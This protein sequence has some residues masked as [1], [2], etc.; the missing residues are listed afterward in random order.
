[1]INKINTIAMISKFVKQAILFLSLLIGLEG[2]SANDKILNY[3]QGSDINNVGYLTIADQQFTGIF[4]SPVTKEEKNPYITATLRYEESILPLFGI[5]PNSMTTDDFSLT[6]T[7]DISLTNSIGNIITITNQT[8]NITYNSQG[9]DT[10]KDIDARRYYGYYEGDL[11]VTNVVYKSFD[12]TTATHSVSDI[13]EDVYLELSSE[14]ERYYEL[15]V[16]SPWN[17]YPVGS[18][19]SLNT[20]NELKISWDYILGAESF[21]V[22]WVFVDITGNAS[23][24]QIANMP[25]SWKNATRINTTNNYYNISMAYPS[26][27]IIY[28]VRPV[29]VDLDNG[30]HNIKVYGD[31]SDPGTT[32][33]TDYAYAQGNGFVHE[34]LDIGKNWTYNVAY[35]E[36]GKRKE[37]ISYFDGSA[38]S[39]QEVTILNSDKNAIVGETLYDFEG[40]PA[41]S[42]LP[43]P[44]TSSGIGFYENGS[45]PF[46][47]GYSKAN[48]DRDNNFVG[49]NGPDLMSTTLALTSNYYSPLTPSTSLFKDF[50]PDADSLPFSRTIYKRDGTDRITEQ[51]GVGSILNHGTA[52][53]TK[54]Y[55]GSP[56][57]MEIERLFGNEVGPAAFYQKN[58]VKDP[59]GQVSIQYLDKEGRTIATALAGTASSPLLD[60]DYQPEPVDIL[61]NLLS[62]NVYSAN[63]SESMHVLTVSTPGSVTLNYTLTGKDFVEACLDDFLDPGMST[64]NCSYKLTISVLDEDGVDLFTTSYTSPDL[65]FTVSCVVPSLDVGTYTITKTLEIDEV[66]RQEYI[67]DFK[68]AILDNKEIGT[69]QCVPYDPP[70]DVSCNMSC[71]ELC[72]AMLMETYYD[73]ELEQNVT[74]YYDENGNSA[75]PTSGIP[76]EYSDYTTFLANCQDACNEADEMSFSICELKLEAMKRQISPGGQYFD[77]FPTKYQDTSP[78]DGIADLD[79]NGNPIISSSYDQYDWLENN[80][81]STAPTAIFGTNP[82]TSTA[83]TWAE[84]EANWTA[85]PWAT[86]V[87]NTDWL[88]DLVKYHPEYCA[89]N[90]NCIE[91]ISI[92]E[93]TSSGPGTEIDRSHVIDYDFYMMSGGSNYLDR[94]KQETIL[95]PTLTEDYMD[96][97][98]PLGIA[99]DITN[100]GAANDNQQ[101]I[102]EVD[103]T[104]DNPSGSS[105]LKDPL[106]SCSSLNFTDPQGNSHVAETWITER[107]QKFIAVNTAGD[108][109]HSIWYVLNDVGGVTGSATKPT[110]MTQDA[111]DFYNNLL[112]NSNLS[113]AVDGIV[114][115]NGTTPTNTIPGKMNRYQFFRGVYKFYRDFILYQLFKEYDEACDDYTGGGDPYTYWDVDVVKDSD[116][117]TSWI[118]QLDLTSYNGTRDVNDTYVAGDE[119]DYF[120]LVW[121]RV[122]PYDILEVGSIANMITNISTLAE[123]TCEDDCD[124]NAN[125]WMIEYDYC[126][127]EWVSN[128]GLTTQ[129]SLNIIAELKADLIEICQL[130]C[131][132]ATPIGSSDGDGT[133][134]FNDV[135]FAAPTLGNSGNYGSLG[136]PA[137]PSSI[138]ATFDD[139]LAYYDS[140]FGATCTKSVEYPNPVQNIPAS[141]AQCNCDQLVAY[142]ASLTPTITP[143]FSSGNYTTIASELSTLTGD[144]YIAADVE[145]W[146]DY[147]NGVVG[148]II[149][150]PPVIECIDCKCENLA[151]FIT[152]RFGFDPYTLSGQDLTDVKD[153]I[154]DEFN[155][156]YTTTDITNMMAECEDVLV[157][158][159]PNEIENPYFVGL[160]DIFRCNSTMQI[161]DP[162]DDCANELNNDLLIAY[163]N[164]WDQQLAAAVNQF[165]NAYTDTCMAGIQT[166]ETFTAEYQLNE[167]MYTL[168]YYDQAGNLIKTVPP[169][170]VKPHVTGSG[171]P[172]VPHAF[173]TDVKN[174]RSDPYDAT[175][176]PS[177]TVHQNVDHTLVT[178]YKY[179]SYNNLIWQS[180]PDGGETQ[181]WYD[182]LGRLVLS[183]NAKQLANGTAQITNIYSYTLYDDLGRIKE[184]GELA[185]TTDF[186]EETDLTNYNVFET[187]VGTCTRTQVTSTYYDTYLNTTVDGYFYNGQQELRTRVSSI[188]REETHDGDKDTYDYATHFSYDIHGNVNEIIQDNRTNMLTLTHNPAK[189]TRITYEY[190]LISGNV[191]KVS[192]QPGK[193]EQYFHRYFYDA[194]NRITHAETSRDNFIWDTDAKYLY[195]EHGPL[196]RTEIGTKQVAGSD[197]AY[198]LQGWIKGVNSNTLTASLDIGRD[199]ELSGGLN[200]RFATD[201][202]GYGLGY[203]ADDYQAIDATF[204]ATT[205]GSDFAIASPSLYNGN[206]RHMVTALLDEGEDPQTVHGTAYRYDQANRIKSSNV[207]TGVT[208]NSFVGATDNNYYKTEHH[209]DLNGN[210]TQLNRHNHAGVWMDQLEY[211]YNNDGNGRNEHDGH[212]SSY[213]Y[214]N[215]TTP[216]AINKNQ[217]TKVLDS[218]GVVSTTDFGIAGITPQDFVYDEIGQLI[219]DDDEYIDEIV[220]DVYNKIK[221]I[222]YSLNTRPDIAFEY[223]GS[224]NRIAKI[225]KYK[226]GSNQLLTADNWDYYYYERDASGN[227]MAVYKQEIA[228]I[229]GNEYQSTLTLIE[230]NIY[231]SSRVGVD[232]QQ[233]VNTSKFFATFTTT[234]GTTTTGTANYPTSSVVEVSGGGNITITDPS[235]E[236]LHLSIQALDNDVTLFAQNINVISGSLS[237]SPDGMLMLL[238]NQQAEITC[239]YELELMNG[240]APVN[241]QPM[242]SNTL[243]YTAANTINITPLFNFNKKQRTIG[244][245]VYEKSNHLGNVL[246]TISDRKF[247]MKIAELDY[248]WNFESSDDSEVNGSGLDPVT[249][250]A[251]Y[252][253]SVGYDGSDVIETNTGDYVEFADDARLDFGTRDFTV[254]VWVKKITQLNYG[255]AVVS[256][257][258]TGA[259]PGTNEWILNLNGGISG[260]TNGPAFGVQIGTTSYSAKKATPVTN[261]GQ[262]YFLVGK[263]EGNTISIYVDG[264]LEDTETIPTGASINNISGRKMSIGKIDAGYYSNMQVDNLMIF[265]NALSDNQIAAMYAGEQYAYYEPNVLSYSD[266]YP[267]GQLMPG[268][269]TGGSDYRYAFNGMEK[270]D[271][272]NNVEG[273]S[274]T[275]HF[276]QYDARLGRWLSI[277][278]E[279]GNLPHQSPYAGMDNNPIALNDPLGNCTGGDCQT[280]KGYNGANYSI[281]ESAQITSQ[282]DNGNVLSFSHDGSEYWFDPSNGGYSTLGSGKEYDGAPTSNGIGTWSYRVKGENLIQV[283]GEGG[284]RPFLKFTAKNGRVFGDDV[285]WG[286]FGSPE[287][288]AYNVGEDFDS[289][290]SSAYNAYSNKFLGGNNWGDPSPYLKEAMLWSIPVGGILGVAGRG[291]GWAYRGITAGGKS[292]AAYK[293][294]YWSTR[295]KPLL[296]AVVNPETGQVWKQFTELHHRFIPQRWKWAPNWL[297][298]NSLNLKPLSSLEHAKLDPYRARFAPQWVKEQFKLKWK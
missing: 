111:F 285:G 28:R 40:R 187:W 134:Q 27:M 65:Q 274:Y 3:L 236:D 213:D 203:F 166:R 145:R 48:F 198:T 273:S 197:Y 82:S 68:N 193:S 108:K 24:I 32:T 238:A 73:E 99:D 139:L 64:F 243:T 212:T 17:V 60:I 87:P 152:S 248:Y 39:R 294:A 224:G 189:I 14:V 258:N 119:R 89:Y 129:D 200:D 158:E 63:A 69:Q 51:T 222:K 127:D 161:T 80:I 168:Y 79:G 59:N 147:C 136:T 85:A 194:D 261:T 208:S 286:D 229:S 20:E 223:D 160:P 91:N 148:D 140:Y 100:N 253:S 245:K 33:N 178:Q 167:F 35:A 237:Y 154:N 94:E 61:A 4:I 49:S 290:L 188:T 143:P 179:D 92:G 192:Y 105:F 115:I 45:Q 98:N 277:D 295:S 225:L 15:V 90:Y 96:F 180:T 10:Y 282:A 257:W 16:P 62:N 269:Y 256:K 165:Y 67:D 217:L 175:T 279:A 298:N 202:Y 262:W 281:P 43:T 293:A 268:R 113:P 151:L 242:N 7:Y 75:D 241:I 5:S 185:N 150:F 114:D 288:L 249:N 267:F 196:A 263:R 9:D 227:I 41:V 107:L 52:N 271:E 71:T 252:V 182:E 31:W 83:Y 155:T 251:T 97:M 133:T 162:A 296:E 169:E 116:P 84:I 284:N 186:V 157:D 233:V 231:G 57:D 23:V 135:G 259:S 88:D 176:N 232:N 144:T 280:I 183:Q 95:N 121:P 146:D 220:W 191:N 163:N 50:I 174:H 260:T 125:A 156:S 25:F 226:N 171:S 78:A 6:V 177:G 102:N 195:Y 218:K 219:A 117:I 206:I 250:T 11:V 172:F 141:N 199:A 1:M 228:N 190:D 201:A 109:F 278:P 244:K 234:G 164:L 66:K 19:A 142:A 275:T 235:M 72:E 283:E 276:R 37:G 204:M 211:K 47:G 289:R 240:G 291:I 170:G 264:V 254:A 18:A 77:N 124:A 86:A 56:A 149:D 101:Y 239:G 106:F 112:G 131:A 13:P 159:D 230:R 292:F 272:M 58:M 210:I 2:F 81:A 118:N 126:I 26:G 42:M 29:G 287:N 247:P 270:D 104:L 255:N 132:L 214:R 38:R 246:V 8:L 93:C 21:D 30:N 137:T 110:G 128:N 103:A 54:Y 265:D 22:E 130:G 215:S 34:G 207:F 266:Y 181:F 123:E 36:D 205:S 122:L 216:P 76:Y 184:V 12:G 46:N 173:F 153:E 44:I 53:T 70:A 221:E 138:V 209:Y 55:Y 297:K 120:T 74:I